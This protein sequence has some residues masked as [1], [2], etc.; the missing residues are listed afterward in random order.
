M[1]GWTQFYVLTVAVALPGL[2]AV[3]RIRRSIEPE[4]MAAAQIS[5]VEPATSPISDRL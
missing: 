2:W 1:V 3:W 5:A 4:Q